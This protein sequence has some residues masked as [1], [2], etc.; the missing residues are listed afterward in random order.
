[1]AFNKRTAAMAAALA[2]GLLAGSMAV[3]DVA[4]A[5]DTED[6]SASSVISYYGPYEGYES[7]DEWSDVVAGKK[8]Q[9]ME[10]LDGI[11]GQMNGRDDVNW[12]DERLVAIKIR[13][14]IEHV[15]SI[16]TADA[17]KSDLGDFE[18]VVGD[19]IEERDAEIEAEEE[20]ARIAEEEAAAAAAA[21]YYDYS[22]Y[23]DYGYSGGGGYASS[24]DLR[25]A[26]VLDNGDGTRL[27]WYSQ[28]V[29]SGGGLSALNGNGRHVDGDTG[30]IMDG[31]GYV[32]VASSDYSQGTVVDLPALGEGV[33][34]KVYDSGC[35]SGTIDVYTDW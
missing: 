7:I 24:G 26:G 25:S 15:Y 22:G 17:L 6:V 21:E 14:D 18:G 5:D 12:D 2:C 8:E 31:D 1:M 9:R 10:Y 35:S 19:A 3:I 13:Q 11:I 23:Y 30:Y 32:A 33:Q 20:A 4:T 29:L 16:A 34:G 27:T 28:R